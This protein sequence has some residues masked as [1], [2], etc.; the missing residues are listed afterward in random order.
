VK[1]LRRIPG[2]ETISGADEAVSFFRGRR[3]ET[4]ARYNR[5]VQPTEASLTRQM[6]SG[7][8][9]VVL[10]AGAAITSAAATRSQAHAP[11]PAG[12]MLKDI[13]VDVNKL[14]T[15]DFEDMS[16]VFSKRHF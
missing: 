7:F 1:L 13:R 12:L 15:E 8:V 6:I 3:P 16:W 9:A 2:D 4:G 10:V 5:L 11:A 14:P